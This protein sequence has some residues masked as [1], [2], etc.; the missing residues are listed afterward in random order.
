MLAMT[1]RGYPGYGIEVEIGGRNILL[2]QQLMDI[3]N[4]SR[5]ELSDRRYLA[6]EGK[7]PMYVAADGKLAGIIAVAD[8]VE[9]SSIDAINMLQSMG[10]EVAMITET[11]EGRQRPS[12]SR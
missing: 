11:T 8:V 7:T 1:V 4:I 12:Q 10:I 9:S 6:G 2:K 3:R 5:T